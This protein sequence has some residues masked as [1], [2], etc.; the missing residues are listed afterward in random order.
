MFEMLMRFCIVGRNYKDIYFR[1]I[2]EASVRRAEE[3]DRLMRED[4]KAQE[5]RRIKELQ[6]ELER[7]QKEREERERQENEGSLEEDITAP[8][9]GK[10]R[11]PSRFAVSTV[12]DQAST[13][14]TSTL[15]FLPSPTSTAGKALA[16]LN[17]RA[18]ASQS[19][20][21]ESQ[22]QIKGILKKQTDSSYT[23]HGFAGQHTIS[24]M[25]TPYQTVSG[26][27]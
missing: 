17:R 11:R 26:A 21:G 8:P 14:T 25:S 27:R 23:I 2:A 10:T 12:D 16:E 1:R 9:Q 15:P 19:P 3:K 13:T 5:D 6:D 4:L 24:P 18:V 7:V 22:R 20:A